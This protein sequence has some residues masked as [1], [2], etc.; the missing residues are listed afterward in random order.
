MKIALI[1]ESSQA[2]KNT[3]ICSI[4]EKVVLPLGHTVR[5]YGMYSEPGSV[6]MSYVNGGILT[7]LL[8]NAGAADLVVTGCNTGVG[9]TMVTNAFPGVQCG[10]VIDPADAFLFSQINNGNVVSLPFGKGFGMGGEIN[11]EYVFEKLFAKEWGGGYPVERAEL[12][13]QFKKVFDGL[14]ASIHPDFMTVLKSIDREL[15]WASV[16]GE[17]FSDYFFKDCRSPEIAEYITGVL[18]P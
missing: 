17:R 1:N 15:L 16:S 14:K 6:A 8:I 9:A 2:A 4:L 5:N 12:Q 3:M 18:K 11:L 10:F 7:A 13:K